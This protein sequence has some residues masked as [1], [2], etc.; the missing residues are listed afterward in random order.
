MSLAEQQFSTLSASLPP[1]VNY[2]LITGKDGPDKWSTQAVWDKILGHK[3]AVVVS[4]HQV[5]S[6][7]QRPCL[8]N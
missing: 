2:K 5:R 6:F 7:P 3:A 4:T 1:A 8:D